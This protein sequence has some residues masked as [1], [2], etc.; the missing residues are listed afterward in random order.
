MKKSN[1]ISKSAG[2]MLANAAL[3][4]AKRASQQFSFI[5]FQEEVPDKVKELKNK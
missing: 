4:V 2:N 5:F 3:N 1:E